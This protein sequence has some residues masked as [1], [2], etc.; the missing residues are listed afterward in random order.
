[1]GVYTH[2]GDR[3]DTIIRGAAD[4]RWGIDI[5]GG[6]DATFAPSDVDLTT[7]TADEINAVRDVIAQRLVNNGITD[8]EVFAD[9]T[10]KQVI[11]RFPWSSGTTDFNVTD[12]LNE[13]GKT[14]SLAFYFD[15]ADSNGN[16]Q[17]NPILTGADVAS[18]KAIMTATSSTDSTLIPAVQL[19]LKASGTQAFADATTTQAASGGTISIWLDGSMVSN[20][21]VKSAI[22]DGTAIISG[23]YSTFA[24]AVKDA[25][26]IN[27][28]AMPFS[29]TVVSSGTINPTLGQEAL[30][31]MLI[32]GIIAFI[33][34]AA[35][36]LYFYK[37]PGFVAVIALFGHVAATIAAVSGYFGF[38]NS[39]TM[40]LPGIAGIILGIGIAVDAN[41]IMAERIKEE[42][43]AGKTIDAAL[44][45]GSKKSFAAIFDGNISIIFVA[46]VLMGVFGPP[47]SL[48]AKL[49]HPV[50]MW[51]PAATTGAIYSF[52]YTLL[53]GI[54]MNF[55]MSV[56]ATRLML[57]SLVRFKFL[58]K[59]WLLG[60]Y[61][62]VLPN[63]ETGE[64]PARKVRKPFDFI[65]KRKIFLRISGGLIVVGILFNVIMGTQL[66]VSF[67]G[68]TL[69][70][71]TFTGQVDQNAVKQMATDALG[72]EPTLEFNSTGVNITLPS[73]VSLAQKDA[74]T[75][76]L[77]A[78]YPD[79]N[80]TLAQFNSLSPTMGNLFLLKC[81]VAIGLA[82]LFLLIYMAFR[83]RRIG[84]ISAAVMAVCAL[85]LDMLMAYF[86]FVIFRIPIN[87]NFVAVV[88][89]ILG[90]SLNGTIVVYDR[91]RENRRIL[92]SKVSVDE[93]VD[94]SL[95][96]SFKRN[97]NTNI[98]TVIAIGVVAVIALVYNL[99]SI[100]S[101]A[102]PMMFGLISGFYTSTF[103]AAP[104]WTMWLEHKE[105]R[106]KRLG[107]ETGKKAKA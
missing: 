1:F 9:T 61:K 107:K 100:T 79:A 87:D 81:F 14:A 102:V 39:F 98:A 75:A 95:N 99:T 69:L 43:R 45:N 5:R 77:A 93:V 47:D 91:I 57:H 74:L 85:L 83:F 28:G 8:Y 71:Y 25:S 42:L 84:G 94:I 101:F 29:I 72:T 18:A 36:M 62:E 16:P 90:Y 13:L 50:L 68:G 11:V 3:K 35:F 88:L 60:G 105:K 96:Q 78:A 19:T 73:E 37:L 22:T 65:G 66:D 97:L 33:L 49:L 7:V 67:K 58:R 23:G 64:I 106:A 59:P 54:I 38:L 4:I 31:V 41:V 76:A 53:L 82:A 86:A 27:S 15:G 104:V 44:R 30:N 32:A 92:S 46:I 103:L 26:L 40:T 89:S 55:V 2:F 12:Q 24:D 10:N 6:V 20:P 63:P 52:G 17:G 21:S 56:G 80:M 51:F 70:M 34:I 48:F